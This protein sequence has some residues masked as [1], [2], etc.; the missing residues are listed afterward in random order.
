MKP[1]HTNNLSALGY[2]GLFILFCMPYI[3]NIALLICAFLIKD[4]AVRNF[5]RAIL[6][7]TV[8]GWVI[9]FAASFVGGFDLGEFD[10]FGGNGVEEVFGGIFSLLG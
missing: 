6:I 4:T 7:L 5:S 8:I 2:I 10:F 9:I 1:L 3:G